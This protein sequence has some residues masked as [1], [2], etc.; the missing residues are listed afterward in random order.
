MAEAVKPPLW[1]VD[2]ERSKRGG[3]P[4]QLVVVRELGSWLSRHHSPLTR[5]AYSTNLD[6]DPTPPHAHLSMSLPVGPLAAAAVLQLNQPA[7]SRAGEAGSEVLMLD[8]HTT[9][10]SSTRLGAADDESSPPVLSPGLIAERLV[11]VRL[12]GVT[13]SRLDIPSS[14]KP[15]YEPCPLDPM[16]PDAIITP[17]GTPYRFV[18]GLTVGVLSAAG[19][20]CRPLLASAVHQSTSSCRPR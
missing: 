7:P 11:P 16:S 12:G 15:P 1:P 5:L 9:T 2:D 8:A 14:I 4:R 17:F 13:P 10:G 20:S 19:S 6:L 18:L 3:G